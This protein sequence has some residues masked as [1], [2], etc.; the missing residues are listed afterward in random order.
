MK[1]PVDALALKSVAGYI[2]YTPIPYMEDARMSLCGDKDGKSNL[3]KRLR[4]IEG[5]VRGLASMVEEERDCIE[6]LRQVASVH[7]ALRGV[8]G[9]VLEEHLRGC[10]GHA[11]DP[12]VSDKL[13]PELI[14]HLK[15]LR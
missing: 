13:I 1:S 7:G 9:H 5:Q 10:V 15:K 14:D 3:I 8:W 4:R 11:I 2:V 6:V 12:V